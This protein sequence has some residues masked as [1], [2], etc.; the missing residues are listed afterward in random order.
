MQRDMLREHLRDCVPHLEARE[1]LGK[2]GME[3]GVCGVRL[4]R[5]I[6]QT[7][8]LLGVTKLRSVHLSCLVEEGGRVAPATSLSLLFEH[9]HEG[10]ESAATAMDLE[11][12]GA[13]GGGVGL[14]HASEKL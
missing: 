5:S 13:R 4:P 12:Q 9:L 1:R 2:R 6:D 8:R 10:W 11:E 14:V 7:N 3:R